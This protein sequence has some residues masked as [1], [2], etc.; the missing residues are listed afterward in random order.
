VIVT[1][2]ALVDVNR[3]DDFADRDAIKVARPP[4]TSATG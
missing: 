3:V 1:I 2:S 4:S